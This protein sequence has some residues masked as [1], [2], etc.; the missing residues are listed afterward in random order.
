[1]TNTSDATSNITSDIPVDVA[2]V[3]GGL[4][5][6]TAA[7]IAA[8]SGASVALLDSRAIGGR[9]RSATRDGFTLNEGGHALYR[10]GGGWDVLTGLGVHPRGSTPPNGAFRAVWNGAVVPL[11]TDTRSTLTSRLLSL[12]SKRRLGAWFSDLPGLAAGAPDIEFGDWL[13]GNRARADLQKYLLALTRL[14]TYSAEPEHL[15][16]RAALHQLVAGAN[17]VAYLDGGWQRL[18]DQLADVAVAAGASIHDHTT[19]TAV[20]GGPEEWAV[21]TARGPLVAASIVLAVPPAVAAGL[22]GDD[23]ACWCERAGPL[24]RA[25]VLDIGGADGP[26]Q[27]LLSTDEPLYVARHAPVAELAPE[28]QALHTAM[29]YLAPDDTGT[30]SEHRAELER[31]V[32]TAGLPPTGER[33][34]ERFLAAPVV[35]WGSPRVGV[36]R[37]TGLELADRGLFVAGDWVG[38]LLLADAS[39]VSGAAAGTAAARRAMVAA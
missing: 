22:L 24:N 12:R 1:M 14:A 25:A 27:L 20:T 11:P 7:A 31:H 32:A 18:V 35:T 30:A 5:G 8:R 36:A 34:M 38:D 28:G 19:A 33:T 4:A 9:A 13:D 15:P 21:E 37:P 6:L 39:I 2:V 3:G 26:H 23:P 17:G 29:R 10:A 16:A